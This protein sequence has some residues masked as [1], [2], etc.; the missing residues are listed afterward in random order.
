L[1]G[2][3]AGDDVADSIF[4]PPGVELA[5]D[6][7]RPGLR[8]QQIPELRQPSRMRSHASS[9]FSVFA[10]RVLDQARIDD[11]TRRETWASS[12]R[13]YEARGAATID[14]AMPIVVVFAGKCRVQINDTGIL[15]TMHP[16]H[17]LSFSAGDRFVMQA[18]R[19]GIA[20]ATIRWDL[21]MDSFDICGTNDAE[22]G[23]A[24][25]DAAE[26]DHPAEDFA[27]EEG[28]AEDAIEECGGM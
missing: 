21:V 7:P 3:V 11:V 19:A 15:L 27:A 22:D 6:G 4:P 13:I 16:L 26:E 10:Q 9:Y 23:A 14:V 12:A 20:Y 28:E 8:R 18:P 1:E 17:W 24:E 2:R 25:D 5:V